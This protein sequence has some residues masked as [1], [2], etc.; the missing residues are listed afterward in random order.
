[1]ENLSY[2]EAITKLEAAA[3]SLQEGSLSLEDTLAVYDQACRL[4]AHCGTQLEN[5]RQKL[6][7]MENVQ[8]DT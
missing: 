7:V 8:G 2:E 6:T 5:A 3:Q 1:M 4:A